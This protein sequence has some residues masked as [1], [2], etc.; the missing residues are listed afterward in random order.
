M[1]IIKWAKIKQAKAKQNIV[2]KSASVLKKVY[3][4]N[5]DWSGIF[6]IKTETWESLYTILI[7]TAIYCHQCQEMHILML[8]TR[9]PGRIIATIYITI[10][11]FKRKCGRDTS[12]YITLSYIKS[13]QKS[14]IWN[15]KS[16]L[17]P[18]TLSIKNGCWSFLKV[19][20]RT[21][22]K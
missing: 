22:F 16:W 8:N 19:Q 7:N 20:N 11:Y 6:Q 14:E 12:I 21:T 9:N 5:K 3:L 17:V 1:S 2:L 10:S 15:M 18:L 4:F 13:V